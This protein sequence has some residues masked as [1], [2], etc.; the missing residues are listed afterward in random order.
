MFV[1]K[2]SQLLLF[3]T[4]LP[5]VAWK[6]NSAGGRNCAA[7][8]R[9]CCQWLHCTTAHKIGVPKPRDQHNGS[10][11]ETRHSLNCCQV[12]CSVLKACWICCIRTFSAT[13]VAS[14]HSR[15]MLPGD[16]LFCKHGRPSA[17]HKPK[18]FSIL[19]HFTQWIP[20]TIMAPRLSFKSCTRVG[21]Q[22]DSHDSFRK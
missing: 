20:E 10:Q 18:R 14:H 22:S 19:H 16:H 9:C 15:T 5:N 4:Q 11:T 17:K 13:A 1:G 8:F 12:C 6:L 7:R 2:A 3:G 21:S